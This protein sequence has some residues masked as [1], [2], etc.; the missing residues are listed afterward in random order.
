MGNYTLSAVAD[1]VSGE[2]PDDT[3]DNKFVGE[4]IYVGIPGDVNGD[5]TVGIKDILIVAKA[6][7]TNPQSPNWNPNADVDCDGNV[8]IKDILI[9]AKN[10]GKTDPN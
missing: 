4:V 10:F 7:G 5:H 8:Y 9:T 2:T 1:T 3:P 6:F